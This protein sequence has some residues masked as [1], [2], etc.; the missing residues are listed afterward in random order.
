MNPPK[1]R[2]R[3]MK[4]VLVADA[5]GLPVEPGVD[6]KADVVALAVEDDRP[7]KDRLLRVVEGDELQP[8]LVLAALRDEVELGKRVILQAEV[9]L[10]IDR[11]AGDRERRARD[12]YLRARKPEPDGAFDVELLARRGI[13]H[14]ARLKLR[15]GGCGREETDNGHHHGGVQ[16]HNPTVQLHRGWCTPKF[17]DEARWGGNLRITATRG[18]YKTKFESAHFCPAVLIGE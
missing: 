1:P 11:A 17:R 4:S 13:S 10:E 12:L 9:G 7:Q 18:E 15:A 5:P 2:S 8:E 14:V 16:T 6:R 3:E